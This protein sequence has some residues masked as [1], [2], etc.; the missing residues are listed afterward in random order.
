MYDGV[1][2]IPDLLLSEVTVSTNWIFSMSILKSHV[3]RVS[4]LNK[5]LSVKFI[6][7]RHLRLIISVARLRG[8]IW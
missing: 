5:K 8:Y 3:V 7:F 4:I 2:C 6:R 1:V